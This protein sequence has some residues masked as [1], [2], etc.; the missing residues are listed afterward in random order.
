MCKR[1]CVYA[2]VWIIP[3]RLLYYTHTAQQV[4]HLPPP[5]S[6]Y[7]RQICTSLICLLSRL[8]VLSDILFPLCIFFSTFYTMNFFFLDFVCMYMCVESFFDSALDRCWLFI[9]SFSSGW[10]QLNACDSF[11]R[12]RSSFHRLFP[13]NFNVFRVCMHRRPLKKYFIPFE[14][15]SLYF[16]YAV[17]IVCRFQISVWPVPRFSTLFLYDKT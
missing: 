11:S 2:S 15:N 12:R 6:I 14:E 4:T 5:L 3:V 1:P 8:M 16:L 13:R 10:K 17:V 9:F 7:I